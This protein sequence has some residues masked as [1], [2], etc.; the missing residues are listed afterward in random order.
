M[1]FTSAMPTQHKAIPIALQGLD[2]L[3]YA[4]TGS[5]STS[6]RRFR[7]RAA[8]VH[9][10]L[11]QELTDDALL[12]RRDGRFGLVRAAIDEPPH[13]VVVDPKKIGAETLLQEFFGIR[14]PSE[15]LRK[16]KDGEVDYLLATNVASRGVDIKGVKTV[17]N[18]DM[19]GQIELTCTG[20]VRRTARASAQGRSISLV[21]A[22]RI[23]R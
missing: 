7:G 9:P 8:R 15:A 1:K 14:R 4:V 19:P 20:W 13:E 6:F 3:G 2:V 16:F 17:V 21:A 23:E 5:G 22:N 18:S 10:V 11:P 12:R